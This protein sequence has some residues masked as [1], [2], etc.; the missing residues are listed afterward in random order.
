MTNKDFMISTNMSFKLAF[1]LNNLDR[2]QGAI[3][4]MIYSSIGNVLTLIEAADELHDMKQGQ[5]LLDTRN[6][7]KYI[8][9]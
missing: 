1:E 9:V 3:D 5:Y 6:K 2:A 7:Y 8:D 4:V